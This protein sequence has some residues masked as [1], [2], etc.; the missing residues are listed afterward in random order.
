MVDLPLL[1]RHL[2]RNPLLR[3]SMTDHAWNRIKFVKIVLPA[4]EIE[5]EL[6]LRDVTVESCI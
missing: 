3:M 1:V 5:T 6:L 4:L 2:L